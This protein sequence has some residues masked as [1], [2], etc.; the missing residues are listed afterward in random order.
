MAMMSDTKAAAELAHK[1]NGPI[2]IEYPLL[3]HKFRLS[4]DGLPLFRIQTVSV[5]ME[6]VESTL[7]VKVEQPLLEPHRLPKEIMSLRV[8]RGFQLDAS[9][10]HETY[11]PIATGFVKLKDHRFELD[12]AS[13]GEAAYHTVTLEMKLSASK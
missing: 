8:P 7:T 10:G 13:N 3:K 1:I 4:I 5:T 12:Y 9:D 6:L 11:L 2:L